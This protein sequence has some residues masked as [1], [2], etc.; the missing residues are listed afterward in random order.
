MPAQT[1][2]PVGKAAVSVL[3]PAK[4]EAENIRACLASVAWA[5]EAVV[6]DSQSSDGTAE[7]AAQSGARLVQFHYVP[8]GP[9]KKNW[10][11]RNVDFRNDWIL[12][13]DADERVTPALA[14]EIDL[15]IQDGRHGCSGYYINRRFYFAG[16]W[17]RHAGYY[18]SWNLRLLRRWAGEYETVPDPTGQTGDNEVH[19]HILLKGKAGWLREPLDHYAYPDISTFV[20]K[21][22]RYSTWEALAQLNG[23]G[24]G[25]SGGSMALRLRWRRVAKNL[26]RQLP[27]PEVV[28]FFYHYILKRGFLD[29]SAGYVFC[30]LLAE[31]EFLSWAKRWE[32]RRHW[33]QG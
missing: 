29:G 11:L 3:I 30:R 17:I 21:H 27:F 2:W 12:I 6:V 1:R 19:E 26:G 9:K 33:K 15:V 24:P 7:R 5:D 31:Y 8:G 28:R 25:G 10:A 14:D 18:P 16:K 32:A 4:N 22:N 23:R 13:L 20:E